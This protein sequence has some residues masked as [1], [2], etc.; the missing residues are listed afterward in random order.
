MEI[1]NLNIMKKKRIV[2]LGSTG[3]IGKTLI[4]IIKKD[5]KKFEIVLLSAEGNFKE[6]LNQAKLF[7]VKNLILNDPNSIKKIKKNKYSKKFKIYNDYKCFEKIFKKKV[8]YVMSSI[9]GIEGLNPTVKI[10]KHTKK[11]AIA[12]K[13]SIICGWDLIK[14]EL[15][16]NKTEFIP[17][18]SEHFSIWYALRGIDKSLID[19]IYLTAS[20]G[21]FL[22]KAI[23]KLHNIKS[24]QA[25]KH[26]NWSMGKKISIDSAT[27][28]NKVFEIIEAKKIFDVSYKKLS[29]LT[30]PQS[31]V[32]AIIKL[33]NGL[34]KIIVHDTNMRVPIFNSLYTNCNSM[35]SNILN[36]KT[37]NNLN[38]RE[39]N[40]RRFPVVKILNK[41]PEKSSLYETILV[42]INDNLVNLFLKNKIKFTDIS[43]K[44]HSILD[45]NEFKKFKMIKVNNI[46]DII[47]LNKIV[48]SKI[49]TLLN[50]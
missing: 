37:L 39:I 46:N 41:M 10:I 31:Y 38:F 23:N 22:Y 43:K 33:N 48:T 21:P 9:S 14:K 47:N 19:Q 45:R 35:K 2:I 26:P 17:V 29:I 11:I 49:N 3:S 15:D 4:N 28:M 30:H 13:E 7:K 6:I 40:N 27:M 24:K 34:T 5:K 20:G 16:K 25:L 18:D 8:D 1:F 36:I 50:I 42:S 12:N 32:H 44:M